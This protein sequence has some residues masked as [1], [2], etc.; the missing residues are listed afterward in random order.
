MREKVKKVVGHPLISGSA[1]VFVGSL[2]ANV[3][4]FLFNLFMNW[5]LSV[6]DYGIL[7]SL[8]SLTTLPPMLLTSIIPTTVIFAAGYIS[9]SEYDKAKGFYLKMNNIILLIASVFCLLFILFAKNIADFV[10]IE[11]NF[12]FIPFSGIIVFLS[13]IVLVNMAFLQAKLSFRF[14][15]LTT[16]LGGFIR[17]A[18]GLV[19]VVVGFGVGGVLVGIIITGMI[20]YL[21]S[22]I[23]LRTILQ[24]QAKPVHVTLKEIGGY[25]IPATLALF[26]IT[27]FITSD[28]LLVKHFFSSHDAGLYAG[29]ALVG[30]VVFYFSA[31]IGMVMFPLAVRKYVQQEKYHMLLISSLLLVLI[32]SFFIT[33]FYFIAPEFTIKFFFKKEEYLAIADKIGLFG[34]Y[35]TVYSLLS[36]LTNF[37]LS[38]KKTK[39]FIPILLG[40]ILQVVLLWFFHTSLF[41]VILISLIITSVL[42]CLLLAFFLKTIFFSKT[43]YGE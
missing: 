36:L 39:V 28:I 14:I 16:F 24:S 15:S 11:N 31:P 42:L 32:P 34:V 12:L 9:K 3:F 10:H 26:G 43:N 2:A 23:P 30:K 4:N 38:I 41:Q 13:F 20:S 27:S 8:I 37:Y 5:N 35:M 40:A 18:L 33:S 22:F 19:M 25:A 6:V 1:V 21:L 7:I 29:L 17:F